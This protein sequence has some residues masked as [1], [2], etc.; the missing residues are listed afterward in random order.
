LGFFSA[1]RYRNPMVVRIAGLAYQRGFG[2]HFHNDNSLAALRD[3]PGVVLAVPARADDAAAL[4]RTCVS[5]A[6]VDGRVCVLVEPIALYHTRDLFPGDGAW[7]VPANDPEHVEIGRARCHGDGQD[8]TIVTF[9]N[10]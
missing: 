10:G 9:G 5:A 2:G 1:G 8:L 6:R 7:A 3:I 4:L